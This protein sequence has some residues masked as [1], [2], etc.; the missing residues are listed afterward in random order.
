MFIRENI[1]KVFSQNKV[2]S[3][4]NIVFRGELVFFGV[5]ICSYSF[6]KHIT[7]VN[8]SQVSASK[9]I[10]FYFLFIFLVLFSRQPD[11]HVSMVIPTT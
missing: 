9:Y 1:P 4:Q 10:P 2:V 3:N 5:V 7:E 11:T 6:P 8:H